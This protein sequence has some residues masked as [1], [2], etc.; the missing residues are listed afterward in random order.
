M[1]RTFS[2][3]DGRPDV[4]RDSR[5]GLLWTYAAPY[6]LDAMQISEQAEEFGF[7][8]TPD[9]LA[10]ITVSIDTDGYH[11]LRLLKRVEEQ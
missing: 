3:V 2:R 4:F 5:D 6:S 9:Q 10:W 8:N 7:S 11:N 1:S